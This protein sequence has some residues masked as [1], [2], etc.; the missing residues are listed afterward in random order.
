MKS[1]TDINSNKFHLCGTLVCIAMS[2]HNFL[3]NFF[4]DIMFKIFGIISNEK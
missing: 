4:R 3:L 1:L 2:P